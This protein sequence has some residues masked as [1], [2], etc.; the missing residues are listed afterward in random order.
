MLALPATFKLLPLDS[1]LTSKMLLQA[2]MESQ[3]NPCKPRV[4]QF[5]L[6]TNSGLK[7]GT[8]KGEPSTCP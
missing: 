1:P 2:L 3:V 5:S 4:C 7:A 6:S 8:P